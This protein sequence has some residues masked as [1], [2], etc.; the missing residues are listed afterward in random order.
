LAFAEKNGIKLKQTFAKE[1]K[2]LKIQLRFSHHPRR[3]KQ[4]RKAFKRIKT[5]ECKLARDVS[6]KQENN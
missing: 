6:R 5:I 2:A 4:A 1:L 3:K